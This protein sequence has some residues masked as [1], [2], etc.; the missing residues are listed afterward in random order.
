[1]NYAFSHITLEELTVDEFLELD[2][3]SGYLIGRNLI[4]CDE[5][6]GNVFLRQG[7]CIKP[8]FAHNKF[9]KENKGCTLRVGNYNPA[10][11]RQLKIKQSK[12]RVGYFQQRFEDYVYLALIDTLKSNNL[13]FPSVGWNENGI[14]LFV[15]NNYDQ[16]EKQIVTNLRGHNSIFKRNK[17]AFDLLNYWQ[18]WLTTNVADE[19]KEFMKN[20]SYPNGNALK[21]INEKG[22]FEMKELNQDQEKFVK[23]IFVHLTKKGTEPLSQ[24]LL[25]ASHI[26]R[27]SIEL[28]QIFDFKLNQCLF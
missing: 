16:L 11:I 21:D 19:K 12:Y 4:V 28:H 5:C 7:D 22:I 13:F 14:S 27:L 15:C 23:E 17:F 10:Y 18:A 25:I 24:S 6:R 3:D 2:G 20:W 8:H 26:L 9:R 1:M